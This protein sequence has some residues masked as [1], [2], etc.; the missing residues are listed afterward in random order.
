[1]LYVI[2]FFLIVSL[3]L[4]VHKVIHKRRM[5]R[6]LGRK[7][8][9]RELTSLTSWMGPTAEEKAKERGTPPSA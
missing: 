8:N 5:E 1:M 9:D 4:F 7:V 2:I 6:T 3:A